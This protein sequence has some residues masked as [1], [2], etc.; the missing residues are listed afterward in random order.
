MVV[1]TDDVDAIIPLAHEFEEKLIKLA[2]KNRLTRSAPNSTHQSPTATSS[3]ICLNAKTDSSTPE[4]IAHDRAPATSKWRF[5]WKLS[6][7]RKEPDVPSGQDP[8]KGAP[9]NFPR[10]MR[11]FAPFYNGLGCA[12]SLCMSSSQSTFAPRT[13]FFPVF[14]GSGVNVILQEF[15]LDPTYSRFGLLI[16]APFLICVS[17]VSCLPGHLHLSP[18]T[19]VSSSAC[20]SLPISPIGKSIPSAV[21]QV[22]L[23][24]FR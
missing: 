17:I 3:D 22:V 7:N 6:S 4:P 11:L 23:I 10:P 5:G 9:G 19:S 8:E 20:K 15:A 24:L 21:H 1:W 12:L 2:W 14:I 16:T 18:L 13:H